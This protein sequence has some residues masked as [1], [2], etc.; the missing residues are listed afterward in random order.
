MNK[1]YILIAVASLL[2]ISC[3]KKQE[4]TLFTS[5]SSDHSGITFNNKIVETDS[6]NILT[7]EYI[8]NGGGVAVGDFNNDGKP[9]LFFTGNQVT[10]KLYLNQGD[11]EFKDVTEVSGVEAADKWKTG[12]AVIDINNDSLLDIYVCAAMYASPEEKANMLYINQGVDDGGIPIFKEMAKE[13][14]VADTGNSM[15]AAFIDY[16]KDGFLDLYVL[17]NVDIH[18]LPANYR[19]KITDGSSLSN[20]RLY[21]NNGDNT[22]TDVTIEAGITIEGYGLGVAISDLDYDGWPDIYVSND[23]LSNDIMYIN[24]GDG[25]FTDKISEFVKHQSK[26]SMGSD[27]ADFNNDGYLDILTLDML[28]ETNYRLKTTIKSTKYN[29]Y[30]MNDRYGYDYQYMRNMLQMGQ[31]PDMPYSEIGLMAGIAKTDWSWSPLFVDADN[32]GRKDILITNGFPRDITDLDFGEFNFNVQKYLSTAQILDSIPVVKIPNYA[33]RNE[34]DGQFKDVGEAWGLSIPSFSNGAAFADLDADGDLDYVVNNINDEAFLFKNN[35]EAKQKEDKNFLQ[36]DLKGPKNNQAGLGT[37]V[38][39]RFGDGTFQYYEHQLNRGYLS[40]VQSMA[41]FGLGPQKT[42]T[43]LEIVWP[44]GKFQVLTDVPSN[45][46]LSIDHGEATPLSDRELAFPLAPKQLKTIYQEISEQIGVNYIHKETDKADFYLQ[47]TL[48]HKLTQNGPRLAKGDINGDGFEDFIIGSSSGHSPTIFMQDSKGTF[49]STSLFEGEEYKKYEETSISLFDLDNDGDLDLYMVSGSNEFDLDSPYY[50]DYLMI[51]QGNGKFTMAKDK[52]PEINS[53]GS[54]VEAEDFDGDGYVDLFVGGRTPF[55]QYPKP[56]NCYLLKNEKG[57]LVDV[58]EAYSKALRTPGMITD[59]KW[60]DLDHDSLKDLILVGEFMPVTIF[61]NKKDSFQQMDQT[62]IQ[63]LSGWWE[64]VL[65]EDFDG[66][67]DVDLLAGNLGEN[68][69]YNPSEER[70]VTML[71]KDFDNNG[72]IDPVMFAYFKSDFEDSTFQPYPVNFWGDLM[73]QSPMFRKKFN[74]FREFATTTKSGLFTPEELEG[75]DELMANHDQTTYFE[76]DGNGQ[77]KMGR[78]PWQTQSSPIKCMITTQAGGNASTDVL[79]IGNDFGNEAFIGRYDAFNGGV[80]LG[81]NKG[82]FEFKNA[83]ES[84]FKVTGD[85][86]DMIQ[87]ERADGGHPYI[88]VTQN[89]GKALV[90]TKTE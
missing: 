45:Q 17:N 67:G 8:F 2:V 49:T 56:D 16:N 40:T 27:V 42:I 3:S 15:N 68:N 44:D 25:T 19:E 30:H 55:S 38:A 87:V 54:V 65:A 62:G 79:M 57:K 52:M 82:T 80:L 7:S 85:A 29:D 10:N 48:P 90:F 22:F 47:P 1:S 24:N 78:L 26:F 33:Y 76:N 81:D 35:L 64:C 74:Y 12:A 13:Y 71:A 70:P 9:D 50:H 53:S 75:A 72:A 14:G 61:M 60:A 77:F 58:T 23:Y 86:K 18:V 6:F 66:D 43:S 4:D 39:L 21:R 28:G 34:G 59:A 63:Q 73:S 32:D 84:G 89:R 31:G 51:N 11:F 36:L 37:K 69:L 46:T 20:D 83:E 5:I 41:H 88:I